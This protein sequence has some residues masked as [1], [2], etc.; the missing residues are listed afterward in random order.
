M[1]KLHHSPIGWV[2]YL[3]TGGALAVVGTII[4][5]LAYTVVPM[6]SDSLLGSRKAAE[7]VEQF[8][9]IRTLAGLAFVPLALLIMAGGSLWLLLRQWA[10]Q[11]RFGVAVAVLVAS[12][13]TVIAYVAPY[14]T[15][16]SDFNQADTGVSPIS[17]S[18]PGLWLALIGALITAAGAVLELRAA[19]NNT[20]S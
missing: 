13:F 1:T 14:V 8:T 6:T 7:I 5:A 2:S 18:G 19:K 15:L 3:C 10:T 17:L 9:S 16:N 12:G 11:W 4:T 20:S